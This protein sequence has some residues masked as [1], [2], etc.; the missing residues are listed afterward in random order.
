MEYPACVASNGPILKMTVPIAQQIAAVKQVAAE[1]RGAGEVELADALQA[2]LQSLVARSAT[3]GNVEPAST[4]T[5]AAVPRTLYKQFEAEYHTFCQ[6][7]TGM[8]GRMDGAQGKALNSIIEYLT[9]NNRTRDAAGAL[10]SWKYLLTHWHQVG[11]F[12]AK[13]KQLTA[14]NKYLVELLETVRKANSQPA[15]K[16]LSPQVVARKKK[17]ANEMDDVKRSLS[18][19][20][21]NPMMENSERFQQE[22]KA[23]LQALQQQLNQLR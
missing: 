12:L 8:N 5:A 1:K 14:I 13:Q 23:K 19:W 7:H 9:A 22:L 21:S 3:A 18:Y 10:K 11:E 17:L 16:E 15:A 6:E 4:L 20:Q 2:A